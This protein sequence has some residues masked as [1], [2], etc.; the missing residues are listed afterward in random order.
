MEDNI[1]ALVLL[2]MVLAFIVAMVFIVYMSI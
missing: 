1:D 2:L